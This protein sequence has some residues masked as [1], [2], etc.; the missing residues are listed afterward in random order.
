MMSPN[1]AFPYCEEEK[2]NPLRPLSAQHFFPW[3]HWL[4]MILHTGATLTP[5]VLSYIVW[6]YSYLQLMQ[7][8]RP[9]AVSV[10][11]LSQ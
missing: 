6:G 3:C 5:N 11:D 4:W 7:A 1:G 9:L 8:G 10:E 2:A